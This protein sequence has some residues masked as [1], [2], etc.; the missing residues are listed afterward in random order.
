MAKPVLQIPVDETLTVKIKKAQ[1][2]LKLSSKAE[3]GRT[4]LEYVL[5]NDISELHERMEKTKLEKQYQLIEESIKE[6]LS[7]KEHTEKQLE[8]LSA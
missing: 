4:L 3:C 6:L 7:K 8:K 5:E 1:K 2:E